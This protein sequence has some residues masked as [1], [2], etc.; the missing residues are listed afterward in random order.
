MPGEGMRLEN[1]CNPSVCDMHLQL[2][3]VAAGLVRGEKT[4]ETIQTTSV[5]V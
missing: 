4:L 5:R 2:W 3:R 1:I